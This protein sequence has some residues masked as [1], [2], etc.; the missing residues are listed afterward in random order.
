M[1]NVL[2][3]DDEMVLRML[4]VDSLEDL[5]CTVDEAENGMEAIKKINET[6]YDVMILDYMMPELTGIELL[7][8]IDSD[9]IKETYVLMLTA[10]TQEKDQ[11]QAKEAG[12]DYFMKKPFSPMELYQIVEELIND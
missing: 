9:R 4:I 11:V 8:E 10:K 1:K 7:G 5:D 12:V 6:N 3:V 2:V